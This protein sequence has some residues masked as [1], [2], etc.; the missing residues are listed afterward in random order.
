MNTC[1]VETVMLK[2]KLAA[3]SISN[4]PE[5]L[6]F[7]LHSHTKDSEQFILLCRIELILY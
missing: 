1:P 5:F 7:Y 6:A 3:A 2:F 4:R